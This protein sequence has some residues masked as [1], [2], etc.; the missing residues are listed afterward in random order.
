MS[1]YDPERDPVRILGERL[2]WAGRW[3]FLPAIIGAAVSANVDVQALPLVGP[4]R[5]SAVF[6]LDGQ[7]YFGHLDDS[8]EGGSLLLRDTYYLEDAK[9]APTN[10]A[11][12]LVKRGNEPHQPADGLRINRDK[13]LAVERVGAGSQVA[14]AIAVQRELAG[15]SAPLLALNR[16][17]VASAGALAIERSAA[18]R[19]IARG[20]AAA[21][22]SLAKVDAQAL[23]VSKTEAQSISQ[24]A[25]ADLRAVRLSALAALGQAVGMSASDAGAYARA[26][27]TRIEGQSFVSDP[28]M[29]LAPDLNAVVVRAAGL[30]AQVADGAVRQLQSKASPSSSPSPPP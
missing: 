17:V 3:V 23:R 29:L 18:E 20:F 2:R 21:V 15:A 9:G 7:A 28:G 11:V 4:E 14:S 1:L 10:L 12:V 5:Q 27:D 22:D 26:A 19:G 8:G 6:L 30:Y 25:V 24:K 13:V 16:P